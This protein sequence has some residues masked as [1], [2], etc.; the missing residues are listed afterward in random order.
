MNCNDNLITLPLHT[1]GDTFQGFVINNFSDSIAAFDY[2][3]VDALNIVLCDRNVV[4]NATIGSGIVFDTDKFTLEPIP[5]FAPNF[6]GTLNG[7][8]TITYNG[9][10]ITL[11]KLSM[12]ICKK[13]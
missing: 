12:P 9:D 10:I 4:L 1:S 5:S 7:H 8:I 6:E 2:L 13:K 11:N 3:L